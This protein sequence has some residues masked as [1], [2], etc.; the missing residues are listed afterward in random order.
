VASAATP[1]DNTRVDGLLVMRVACLLALSAC[2]DGIAVPDALVPDADED[3]GVVEVHLVNHDPFRPTSVYFQERDSTLA[4]A[5][6]LDENGRAR[7]YLHPHGFVT[8]I[9]DVIGGITPIY[10]YSN[11]SPGDELVIDPGGLSFKGGAQL[12][13]R[14]PSFLGA[15]RYTLETPCNVTD[16]TMATIMPI[17]V[18]LSGCGTQ[19]DLLFVAHAVA[20]DVYFF[21]NDVTLSESAP[22]MLTL[23]NRQYRPFDETT[24]SI[25]NLPMQADRWFVEKG[26]VMGENVLHGAGRSVEV[27]ER[28]ASFASFGPSV[29]GI[30]AY[31]AAAAD[32]VEQDTRGMESV[33]DWRPSA[34]QIVIDLADHDLRDQTA[35]ARYVPGE[36]KIAWSEAATGLSPRATVARMQ[37]S[38][39]ETLYQWT[40]LGKRTDESTE[41]RLDLPVLPG[42]QLV[43]DPRSPPYDM[44]RIAMSK[45]A[46]RVVNRLLGWTPSMR[47]PI[48][49][50]AGTVVWQTLSQQ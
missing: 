32:S 23:T 35:P 4:L 9:P 21:E 5:T 18:D 48:E 1:A 50:D 33:I 43:P 39:P 7:G 40:I 28:S 34:P 6:R 12:R 3:R 26:I 17:L 36:T 42:T 45:D 11:V 16:V 8:V 37:W 31:T 27:I 30:I 24:S 13:I 20:G 41:A 29:P 25:V 2:G 22:L 44:H 14:I 47:W 19:T 15:D 38:T 10:T 49:G 46:E